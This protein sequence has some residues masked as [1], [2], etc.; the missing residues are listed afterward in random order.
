VT[1]RTFEDKPAAR[2]RVPLLLG[3]VGP[4]SS[5]KTFSAL[6]L[7]TGMQ[8]VI[9][10]EIFFIDTEARRGTHYADRFEFRH[11]DFQPPF[12]PLDYLAAIEHCLNRGATILV[13]DSMTHEHSGP[14]GV[15]DQSEQFLEKKCGDD[16]KGREKNLMLSLVRPKAQRKRLNAAIVQLGVNAIF[17][18]RASDKIKPVAGKEPLK[19]GWQPETTSPLHYEMTQR[20]LLTPG[21]DGVPALFPETDAE[22]RLVKNPAQFRDIFKPGEPLSEE[23]GQKLAEWAAGAAVKPQPSAEDLLADYG[24]CDDQARL[25]ELEARRS[26]LW[27]SANS[28]TQR[29]LKAA[30]DGA[31]QRIATKPERAADGPELDDEGNPI[32]PD[33]AAGAL[34]DNKSGEQPKH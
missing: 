1:K 6:R 32:F 4:S 14:G 16:W 10:G 8:R 11:L 18:Y 25:D 12:G 24:R 2:E 22:K 34:F 30:S 23:V 29:A 31:K 21:C 17:C 19:L 9:G 13:I 28:H 15:M 27:K 26:Q 20:F 5:G 7:A 3:L 33:Q